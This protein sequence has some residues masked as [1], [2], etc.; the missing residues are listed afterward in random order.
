MGAVVQPNGE[1]LHIPD[2]WLPAN[3]GP[4]WSD[5]SA[6]W[7]DVRVGDE[8]FAEVRVHL[9]SRP[10]PTCART[11]M[12]ECGAC[13]GQGAG[14]RGG[15]KFNHSTGRKQSDT[16][17]WAA[18]V[19]CSECRGSGKVP[20]TVECDRCE[21]RG[22][23]ERINLGS[24][25]GFGPC[26]AKCTDG[27]VPAPGKPTGRSQVSLVEALRPNIL[28]AC[29]RSGVYTHGRPRHPRRAHGPRRPPPGQGRPA[30]RASGALADGCSVR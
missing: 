14:P 30:R 6:T 8:R 18:V 28:R 29:P 7:R 3:D 1:L 23:V 19:P 24:F 5:A 17:P 15:S 10:C 4:P 9:C 22:G 11:P 12:V 2:D 26:P 25:E 20:E 21:G 13:D 16:G 27:R